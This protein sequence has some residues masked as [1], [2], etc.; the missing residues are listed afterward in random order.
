MLAKVAARP[1]LSGANS[2]CFFEVGFACLFLDI[3]GEFLLFNGIPR[4]GTRRMSFRCSDAKVW[5][6]L[7]FGWVFKRAFSLSKFL[8]ALAELKAGASVSWIYSGQ[9]KRP[10]EHLDASWLRACDSARQPTKLL[11]E[12]GK[13]KVGAANGARTVANAS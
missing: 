10:I 1:L 7:R 2:A 5:W 4:K 13:L 12:S 9:T 11:K 3:Y 8:I 6:S